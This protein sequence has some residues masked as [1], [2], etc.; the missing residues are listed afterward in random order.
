MTTVLMVI[1][2]LVAL[3]FLGWLVVGMFRES[4]RQSRLAMV[5]TS[6]AKAMNQKCQEET[7]HSNPNLL[8]LI[9]RKRSGTQEIAG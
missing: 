6:M 3:A 9:P 7:G 8:R 4:R 5:T 2:T 1:L